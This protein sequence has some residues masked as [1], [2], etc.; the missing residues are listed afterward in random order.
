MAF[1]EE[2]GVILSHL[3]H[4]PPK[5]FLSFH[6]WCPHPRND[7]SEQSDQTDQIRELTL[8]AKAHKWLL[9]TPSVSPQTDTQP[10]G[11]EN[12]ELQLQVSYRSNEIGLYK[13]LVSLSPSLFKA[14]RNDCPLN[15]DEETEAWKVAGTSAGSE[16]RQERPLPSI[17]V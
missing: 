11:D 5:M 14:G 3:P 2:T 6:I 16:I 13:A 1:G 4:L 8:G 7:G 17:L 12:P 15:T 10:S 9:S